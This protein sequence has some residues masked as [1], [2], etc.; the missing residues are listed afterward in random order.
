M[1]SVTLSMGMS[2]EVACG[3]S[4][5]PLSPSTT[6]D[7]ENPHLNYGTVSLGLGFID[8]LHYHVYTLDKSASI[9]LDLS[10]A[11]GTP[12]DAAGTG[13]T[14]FTKITVLRVMLRANVD[15]SAGSASIRFGNHGTAPAKL[16]LGSVSQTFDV[17]G[18]GRF[19]WESDTGVARGGTNL[20]ILN[21][22]GS[23]TA[24][25]SLLIAG[26]TA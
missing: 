6:H 1:D 10:A 26:R 13:P 25:F 24:T 5:S 14:G 15:G 19:S 17:G 18:D 9:G 23:N 21:L 12:V 3:K 7:Y 20:K 11:L 8:N 4:N 2:Q 22:D 16:F